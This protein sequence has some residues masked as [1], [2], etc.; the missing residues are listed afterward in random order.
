MKKIYSP[1]FALLLMVAGMAAFQSCEVYINDDDYPGGGSDRQRAYTISG[2]W[3]GD[4]GMYYTAVHPYTRQAVTFDAAYSYV[5]FQSDYV[6]ARQGWGKQID[7][8]ASGPYTYQYY[9]FLWEVRNGVLYIEYPEDPN[10]NVAI[11]D[12]YLSSNT[13]TGRIGSSNFRFRLNSLRF[14]NWNSFSGNYMYGSNT[15]WT[16]GPSYAPARSTA[17][18]D[19]DTAQSA[20]PTTI[21]R[22]RK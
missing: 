17:T 8:Y 6:G 13:F 5:L 18:L 9:R 19:K 4:F 15:G 11:Y 7:Y 21:V 3:Q 16:W 2:E 22:H 10:L 12:Y 1:L 20:A 14:N